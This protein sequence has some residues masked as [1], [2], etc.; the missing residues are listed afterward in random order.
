MPSLRSQDNPAEQ[1]FRKWHLLLVLALAAGVA[2]RT[3]AL[4]NKKTITHDEGVTYLSATGHQE[5]YHHLWMTGRRPFG[6]WVPA[7]ELTKLISVQEP[8]CFGQIAQGLAR[9]DSH[10][11]LYFWLLH[12]WILLAGVHTWTGP[13]LNTLIVFATGLTLFGL[14]RDVLKDAWEAALVV[15]LWTVSPAVLP[16]SLQARAYDL[17]GWL[18]VAFARVILRRDDMSARMPISRLMWLGLLAAAGMLTHYHFGLV[19]AAGILCLLARS[20][21]AGFGRMAAV[22][23]AL[24]GGGLLFVACHPLFYESFL[25]QQGQSRGMDLIAV[26]SRFER[27][28]LA[29]ARFFVYGKRFKIAFVAVVAVLLPAVAVARGLLSRSQRAAGNAWRQTGILWFLLP[30]GAATFLLYVLGVSPRHAMGGRYLTAIWPFFAFV[31]VL[32]IRRLGRGRTTAATLLSLNTLFFATVAVVRP[33]YQ[34]RGIPEP[35]ALLSRFDKLI[36]DNIARGVLPR[37]LLHLSEEQIVLAGTQDFLFA[38]AGLWLPG[39]DT[40]TAYVSELSYRSNREGQ[41]RLLQLMREEHNPILIAEGMWH[42]D[43][44]YRFRPRT[45]QAG[46]ASSP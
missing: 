23:L 11:P 46:A 40:S 2:L 13:L 43:S 35:T 29:L 5:T 41:T 25:R 24:A 3:Y 34:Q 16:I 42:A 7:S 22:L 38:N 37:I 10:P 44:V 9:H 17:F 31:P 18:T 6:V 14:A 12:L 36:V 15:L 39:L 1:L 28:L 21:T 33:V 4:V 20:R 45:R 8:F 26:F 19:I 30:I 32:L 27:I